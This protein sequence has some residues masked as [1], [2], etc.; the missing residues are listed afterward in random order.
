MWLAFGIAALVLAALW[1]VHA[2]PRSP[3]AY[4]EQA[5]NTVE[6][7]RSQVQSARL[8]VR[9]VEAGRVLHPSATVGF[10]EAESDANKAVSEFE[11]Y[12]PPKRTRDL[13]TA[14]SSL[15]TETT[16]ALAEL[17]IAAHR[18]EWQHLRSV[19][20]PLAGLSARLD[21]LQQRADLP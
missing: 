21:A 18:G 5:A 13:R 11:G 16:T 4:R 6:K 1:F 9:E 20:A 2:P 19:A 15:G 8:W 3:G 17:R 10:Q 7:L 14:V 12:D